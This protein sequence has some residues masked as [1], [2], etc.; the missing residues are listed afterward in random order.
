MFISAAVAWLMSFRNSVKPSR[1]WI[2]PMIQTLNWFGMV[3]TGVGI[4]AKAVKQAQG[5]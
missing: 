4:T 1:P 2:E 3:F 5:K